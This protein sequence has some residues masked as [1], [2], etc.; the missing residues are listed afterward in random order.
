MVQNQ[1][2]WPNEH[3]QIFV[4]IGISR[5]TAGMPPDS[6]QRKIIIVDDEWESAIIKA[7]RR[8]L[9]DEGW[10]AVVVQPE[11]N[12]SPGD[13]FELATMYAIEE[14]RPDGVLLDVRFGEHQDDR[15]RG[16]AILQDIIERFPK[17]PILMFTQYVQGPERGDCGA[18]HPEVG[19][20][21]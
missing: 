15:F 12:W 14:E 16:L 21:C 18:G 10:S 9:E 17:L 2:R 8:R 7:V 1:G 5:V 3:T 11:S 19:C 13:E 6:E 20:S 4:K